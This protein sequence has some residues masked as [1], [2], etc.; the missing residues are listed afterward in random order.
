MFHFLAMTLAGCGRA[1]PHRQRHLITALACSVAAAV[2]SQLTHTQLL[3]AEQA[4]RPNVILI[5]LVLLL[6]S[7]ASFA[8]EAARPNILIIVPD[9]MR[10]SAMACNGN[11]D[12]RTPNID[13]LAAEGVRFH[14]TYANVPV[15]CPARATLLTGT[16]P[17]VNG[18]VA[19]DLRLGEGQITLAEILGDAGYRTG[20]V[21]KW[22][23]GGS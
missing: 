22:H 5:L 2:A 19:N 16:Y 11:R 13:R 3:A 4:Q 10:A 8:T 23:L 20:F 15:C 18:M 21:G 17:P 1:F 7:R 6:H 12:L 14:R 9:Q